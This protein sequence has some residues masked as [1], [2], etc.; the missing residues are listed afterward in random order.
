[1]MKGRE[2]SK[3]DACGDGDAPPKGAGHLSFLYTLF[4]FASGP[5]NKQGFVRAGKNTPRLC[6]CRTRS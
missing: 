4:L 1:M 2:V 5:S 3:Q 6:C